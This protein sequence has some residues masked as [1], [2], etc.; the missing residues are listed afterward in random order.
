MLRN[1]VLFMKTTQET[2]DVQA[3]NQKAQKQKRHT[4]RGGK[5]MC[6]LVVVV[7]GGGVSSCLC[8][9]RC[10]LSHAGHTKRQNANQKCPAFAHT[11]TQSLSCSRGSRGKQSKRNGN[12]FSQLCIQDVGFVPS[13]PRKMHIGSSVVSTKINMPNTSA[14]LGKKNESKSMFP[15]RDMSF[16]A[17]RKRKTYV[18]VTAHA[19]TGVERCCRCCCCCCRGWKLV[20]VVVVVVHCAF[21]FSLMSLSCFV[22]IFGLMLSS[23]VGC[24]VDIASSVA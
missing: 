7:G 1:L 8:S 5:R 18:A 19:Y 24:R 4:L 6:C 2:R 20:V 3:L 23:G 12:Q 14:Y 15:K 9:L 13:R 10:V 11:K 21:P 17:R 22:F 16:F